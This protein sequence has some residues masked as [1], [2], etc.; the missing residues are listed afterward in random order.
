M[1][2]IISTNK[3]PAAI[4]PYSQAT[5]HNGVIYVSGQLPIDPATGELSTGNITE[6]TN[7]A[8]SNLKAIVGAAGSSMDKILKCTILLTDMAHF[9]EMNEVYGKFFSNEPPARICYQV[10]ALPKGAIVEIDCIAA[11]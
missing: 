8:M 1:K 2:R 11:E 9:A 3:A 7:I 4:G 6:Q 10:S 5:V